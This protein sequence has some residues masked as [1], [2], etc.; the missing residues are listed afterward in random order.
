M[1]I[2]AEQN[3]LKHGHIH[4]S[5]NIV[6]ITVNDN[7][8]KLLVN[9]S[10]RVLRLY[11]V[12]YP[13][14]KSKSTGTTFEM[15]DSFQDVINHNRWINTEFIKLGEKTKIIS[16]HQ[17]SDNLLTESL[18]TSDQ[19]HQGNPSTF[20]NNSNEIFVGSIGEL[21]ADM[22]KFYNVGGNQTIPSGFSASASGMIKKVELQ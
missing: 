8:R 11:Q 16:Q 17:V 15:V 4:Q 7:Y 22:I 5:T 21:S 13:K 3:I 2:R 18:V 19:V 14:S 1:V 20:G 6:S 10:D 12:H 9:C